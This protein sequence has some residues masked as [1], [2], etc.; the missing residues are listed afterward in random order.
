[1][2]RATVGTYPRGEGKKIQPRGGEPTLR[3][4]KHPPPP[5]TFE[6][7]EGK[8]ASHAGEVAVTLEMDENGRVQIDRVSWPGNRKFDSRE[9][10]EA[11]AIASVQDF[12]SA[13]ARQVMDAY[14]QNQMKDGQPVYSLWREKLLPTAFPDAESIKSVFGKY[15]PVALKVK[16]VKVTLPEEFRVERKITGDPLEGMPELTA[17]PPEFEPEGRYMQER[18]EIIDK[19]HPEGFLM[20]PLLGVRKKEG[21]SEP[22]SSHQ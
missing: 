10:A 7:A 14:L 20:K 16:P 22:T 11:F 12:G 13:E 21:P 8:E 9:L 6:E 5:T 3:K 4:V 18:K 15:K 17:Y 1:M 19:N 2:H